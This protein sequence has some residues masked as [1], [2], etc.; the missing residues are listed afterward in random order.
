MTYKLT[1]NMKSIFA[2]ITAGLLLLS[3]P[4]FAQ[5]KNK[6]G[7]IDS[8]ELLQLMPER[9]TAEKAIEDEAKV[10]Q[11]TLQNMGAE[12]EKLLGEYQQMGATSDLVRQD[13]EKALVGLQE[14]IQQFQQSAD[15]T[16]GAKREELLQPVIDK[17]RKAIEDVANENGYTYVFDTSVGVVIHYPAG[18]DILPLVKTKLGL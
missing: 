18:D 4:S 2:I 13:K 10:L 16:L 14:R 8:E 11:S 1:L 7:H 15:Q 6:F 9:T 5:N 3:A 17:A 12:Y